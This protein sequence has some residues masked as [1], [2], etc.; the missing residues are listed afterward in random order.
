MVYLKSI[1][2]GFAAVVGVVLLA[3]LGLI[4][5][6]WWMTQRMAQPGLGAVAYEVNTPWILFPAPIIAGVVFV[7]GFWWE[8]RRAHRT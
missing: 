5:W 7:L 8:F 6:T 2:A 4:G 3:V 1:L